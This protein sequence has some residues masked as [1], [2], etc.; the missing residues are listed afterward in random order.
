MAQE[1]YR[2][3][4][5][6]DADFWQDELTFTDDDAT[7]VPLLDAELT[8]HPA[9]TTPPPD[10]VWNVGNGK[11]LMPSEGVI[12]FEVLLEEIAA[13]TWTEGEYCLAITYT[14]EMRDFSAVRGPVE[15]VE[16]C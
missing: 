14:N 11:L 12:R 8:I 2:I 5:K 13:Y 7:L 9:G 4:L 3:I 16:E 1:P 6:K 15:V 10:V